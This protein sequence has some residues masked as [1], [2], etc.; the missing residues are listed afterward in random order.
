M[1]ITWP[2]V[3]LVL[4]GFS[5]ATLGFIIKKNHL[6]SGYISIG[7]TEVD[8]KI[9]VRGTGGRAVKN[10]RIVAY[11]PDLIILGQTNNDG[12]LE[13]RSVFN[14]GKSIVLQ[15]DGVAFKM[16]RDLLIPRSQSYRATVFF[17]LAEVHGGHATLISTADSE[18]ISLVE[19]RNAEPEWVELDLSALKVEESDKTQFQKNIKTLTL[20]QPLNTKLKLMCS[21]LQEIPPLHECIRDLEGKTTYN[22]LLNKLP[23]EEKET[24][25]WLTELKN[26]ELPQLSKTPS[27]LE[28]L[29][30]IRNKNQKIRAFLNNEPLIEWK[31]KPKSIIFR[32]LKDQSEIRSRP[33]DLTVITESGQVLQKK[34]TLAPK[35]RFVVTRL[36]DPIELKLSQRTDRK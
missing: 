29:F 7:K 1:K 14:S 31:T 30:V 17:D 23:L 32:S 24:E 11:D 13:T 9:T 12:L 4:A 18:S 25:Q 34:I 6:D 36:P 26:K 22:F 3:G 21:T 10:A 15:A 28:P 2:Q 8:L 33:L 16:R 19:K 27:Q 35:R 20:N 5:A